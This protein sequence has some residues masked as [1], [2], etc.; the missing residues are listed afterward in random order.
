VDGLNGLGLF[1]AVAEERSFAAAARRLGLSPSA[2]G[3]AV[4]RLEA[5]LGIPLF[6]RTTR[7]V[8][9]TAEGELLLDRARRIR[10]E[11]RETE[12]S[13]SQGKAVPHGRLRVA[14][15]AVGHRLLAPHL[16]A[17]AERY[18]HVMLDLDLDDRI[19]DLTMGRIDVAIRSGVLADSS[20]R[21]RRLR[22][23]R[24]LLCAAP[25]YIAAAG[26]PATLAELREHRLVRYRYPGSEAL[27]PWRFASSFDLEGG[28]PASICTSME[29]FR[30]P[31]P[32]A[33]SKWW[34]AAFRASSGRGHSLDT[35]F[36]GDINGLK[37][38]WR[39]AEAPFLLASIARF[40]YPVGCLACERPR[41]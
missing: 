7:Q 18:P 37:L 12:A 34:I 36:S 40:L 25:G 23:F 14:T 31:A 11:W 15:P 9:L 22:D 3:K 28:E 20:H 1:L 8:S 16:A 38:D 29:E 24:F 39:L 21:S 6:N 41:P 26:M 10:E 30:T 13:L 17:F 5:R 4:A 2:T 33:S 19:V 35:N 32:L 27:Q